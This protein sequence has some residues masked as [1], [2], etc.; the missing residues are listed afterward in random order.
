[1]KSKEFFTVKYEG[2]DL[3]LKV[4]DYLSN[5]AALPLEV[6][7][8]LYVGY[9]KPFKNMY[10]EFSTHNTEVAKIDLEYFDGSNWV[11]LPN[12]IDE[13][14][15][16]IKSGF[17]YFPRPA[18]WKSTEVL[19]DDLFYLRVKTDVNLSVGTILKGLNILLSN[20]DD[21]AGIRSNIV[22]KHNNG[23]S[24]VEK[25]EAA[26]KHVI[27]QLRNLGYRKAT[28]AAD[29]PIYYADEK[30]DSILYSDLTAFDLLEPFELREAAKF[31]ALSFIYLDELSDEEDDK[32]YRNGLRHEKRAAQALNVYMLKIDSDDDGK[33]DTEES[34]GN[35]G[36][37]LTWV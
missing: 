8:Y 16:F 24:W 9:Y 5:E 19:D 37:V 13:T 33:E 29:S 25:H 18:N 17:V 3:S 31:Y 10:L 14:E 35:T 11:E 30:E 2:T 23:E 4:K 12:V 34:E 28:P 32:W 26:R 6:G 7:Q 20:D 15:N 27:Q 22:S 21:L 36:T 1:M